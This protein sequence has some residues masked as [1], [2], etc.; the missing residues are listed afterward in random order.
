MPTG[1]I[2]TYHAHGKWR[3]RVDGGED[4]PDEYDVKATAVAAGHDE[5]VRRKVAHLVRD[6]DEP[7]SD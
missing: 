1:D 4:L 3:N 6:L 5:A 7:N 2:E